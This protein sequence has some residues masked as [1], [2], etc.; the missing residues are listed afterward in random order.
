MSGDI[1]VVRITDDKGGQAL[2]K[3]LGETLGAEDHFSASK[4]GDAI[5]FYVRARNIEGLVTKISALK[6]EHKLFAWPKPDDPEWMGLPNWLNKTLEASARGGAKR[7]ALRTDKVPGKGGKTETRERPA[8]RDGS[9]R[10]F[11]QIASDVAEGTAW[12]T[13]IIGDV[14]FS[15]KEEAINA[16]YANAAQAALATLDDVSDDECTCT[17]PCVCRYAVTFAPAEISGSGTLASVEYTAEGR[18][19]T[20]TISPGRFTMVEANVRWTVWRICI[21][22]EEAAGEGESEFSASV[23]IGV[24]TSEQPCGAPNRAGETTH[25]V[26]FEFDLTWTTETSIAAEREWTS[27]RDGLLARA[28]HEAFE[29]ASAEAT[30]AL[31]SLSACPSHCPNND[32]SIVFEPPVISVSPWIQATSFMSYLL[33]K[34]ITVVVKWR[35]YK[36]CKP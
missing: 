14:D 33:Q 16:A 18:G 13:T 24:T 9:C 12:E 17:E 1:L 4:E 35:A 5:V 32:I 10:S 25:Q 30:S 2:G 3:I 23:T 36:V 26:T 21:S 31:A 27:E 20:V 29:K 28:R 19:A 22:P 7:G 8:R 34:V 15:T 6:L 11:E